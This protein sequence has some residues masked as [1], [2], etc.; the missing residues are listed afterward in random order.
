[1]E[2]NFFCKANKIEILP[3]IAKQT[4]LTKLTKKQFGL[5]PDAKT[6]HQ[7]WCCL[8]FNECSVSIQIKAAHYFGL[9]RKVG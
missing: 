9:F 3:K 7:I 6:M 8:K 4:K 5:K 2:P 1:M